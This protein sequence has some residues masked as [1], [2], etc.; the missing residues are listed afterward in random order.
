MMRKAVLAVVVVLAAA[1][2]LLLITHQGSQL[3]ALVGGALLVVGLPLLIV[4]RVQLG[5]AFS[6]GPKATTLVTSGLYA[7]I[8][9]PMF[10]FLDVA[11]LGLVMVVRQRWLVGAW[12]A[13][14]AAH[15]WASRREARVLERAFGGSYRAYRARTWW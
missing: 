11:L 14:V 3:N 1:G 13:L 9:H 10:A 5:K 8:P 4:S 6:V 12:L 2:A 7:K 15:A